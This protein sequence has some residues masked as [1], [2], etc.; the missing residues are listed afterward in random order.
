MRTELL[1]PKVEAFPGTPAEIRIEVLNTS[2]VIDGVSIALPNVD[3]EW[4]TTNS[5]RQSLFPDATKQLSTLVTVPDNHPAG[6]Y[7]VQVEVKSNV[8]ASD[9]QIHEVEVDVAGTSGAELTLHPTLVTRGNRGRFFASVQNIGNQPLA[10]TLIAHDQARA[11]EFDV[12]P[13]HLAV[14]PG[15]RAEAEVTAYG[16]RPLFGSP[17]AHSVSVIAD[18]HG[19]ELNAAATYNQKPWIPRGVTTIAILVGI[20]ALWATIFTVGISRITSGPASAKAVPPTFTPVGLEASGGAQDLDLAAVSGSISGLVTGSASGE[21]VERVTVEV[22]RS[23]RDGTLEL[24]ASAASAEDGS[25]TIESLLPSRYRLRFTA[26]GFADRWYPSAS[27]SGAAED[28]VVTATEDTP[29]TSIAIDG[30]PGSISAAVS[31][32]ALDDSEPAVEVSVRQVFD[33]SV[34]PIVAQVPTDATGFF[35][36]TGLATPGTYQLTFAAEGFEEQDLVLDLDGGEDLVANTVRMAAGLGSIAGIVSSA[37]GPLGG[38]TITA[39]SGDFVIETKTPTAGQ[40]GIYEIAELETPATYIIT[41]ELDGFG[42]ETLALDLGPGEVRSDVD[43]SLIGG[44]G[45]LSGRVTDASGLPL[46][47]VTVNVSG[48]SYEAVTQTLTGGDVGA[49]A[50]SEIPTPGEYTVTFDL[51]GFTSETRALQLTTSGS[52]AGFDVV[53]GQSLGSIRGSVSR[54]GEGVGGVEVTVSD[55][56]SLLSTSTASQPAGAYEIGGLPGGSYT[57]TFRESGSDDPFTRLVSLDAGA[58]AVVDIDLS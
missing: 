13:V 42:T 33:D 34:G 20:I 38:V 43:V 36:A 14:A 1:T 39:S 40:V 24:T 49:F 32:S 48:G 28:V 27:G 18:T 35:V 56:Q 51:D 12:D 17:I 10:V 57:V 3:P 46:G 2:E 21:G 6:T 25:Y 26:P 23:K 52:A 53:M 45:S 37:V 54:N 11:L 44:T 9:V 58:T 55:G 5:D 15:E 41:F 4:I 29:D 31:I 50:L 30:L 19:Q 47:G 7:N 16:R 8:N 22:Y